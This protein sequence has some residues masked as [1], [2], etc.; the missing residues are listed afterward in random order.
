MASKASHTFLFTHEPEFDPAM[1]S[2][3][4]PGC[5]WTQAKDY[6]YFSYVSR[7]DE[8]K[9]SP[10]GCCVNLSVPNSEAVAMFCKCSDQRESGEVREDDLSRHKSSR[11]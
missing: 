8:G 1:D 2:C 4:N 7:R 11:L 9:D 3:P 5:S 10:A 6:D